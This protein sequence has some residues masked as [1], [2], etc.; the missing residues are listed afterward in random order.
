LND[1]TPFILSVSLLFAWLTAAAP[2]FV[3]Q[4]TFA[5]DILPGSAMESP[6]FLSDARHG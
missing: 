2:N 4:N 5:L 6:H 3:W 1:E